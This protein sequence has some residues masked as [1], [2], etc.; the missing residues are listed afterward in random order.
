MGC[1]PA[2][3]DATPT[4]PIEPAPVRRRL[5]PPPDPSK[6]GRTGCMAWGAVLGVLV[7]I[8]L[9]IYA[10]PPILKSIYGTEQVAA[11]EALEDGGLTLRATG[12]REVESGPAGAVEVTLEGSSVEGWDDR[13]REWTLELSGGERLPVLRDSVTTLRAAG[14]PAEFVLTFPRLPTQTAA[15]LYLHLS[16][17]RVRFD[18]EGIATP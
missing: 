16:S 9:A 7:G 10:L 14:E 4:Q 3:D 5:E 8:M 6:E 13:G 18:L 17:P 2:D 12:V 15:P 11:G 1:V